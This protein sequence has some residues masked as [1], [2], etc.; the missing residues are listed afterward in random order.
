MKS[1]KVSTEYFFAKVGWTLV[2]EY[3]VA[4]LKHHLYSRE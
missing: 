1:R 2:A 3:S 4:G